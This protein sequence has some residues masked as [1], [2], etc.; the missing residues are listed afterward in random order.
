M[1]TI[2]LLLLCSMGTARLEA[3]ELFP[4]TE[5]ASTMPKQ[6]LGA[7]IMSQQYLEPNDQ[8]RNMTG[9]RLMYG[10]TSKLTV[11]L[12]A[13]VSNHHSKDLPPD[14]PDHNTPQ[15]G[16]PLPL[17]F[18]GV[19]IYA[20]YR[21][22]SKDGQNSHFRIGAYAEYSY[23]DVAHDEAEPNLM[24]DT[25]GFGGGIIATYLKK[26]F[27]VSFTGGVILPADYHGKVPDLLVGLP[28]VPATVQYGRAA[29][30][31]LSFGY[32][33][34]PKVYKNYNQTNLNL[35]IELLGKSYERAKVF[36]DNLGQPGTPYEVTGAG[37]QALSAGH[38]IEVHPG[39]QA[40]IKSNLR[41]D[42]SVGF[43]MVRKS[44][45]HFYPLYSI[46]IQRYFYP[47]AKK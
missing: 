47:R 37:M 29:N 44:Y 40:I 30:Y 15:I 11:M 32:L 27:A 35:Y 41:I 2:L 20:K 17:R 22:L 34:L 38:Y 16:V 7:R 18:N 21:L 31:S 9:I 43:P 45:A 8:Y 12:N 4:L 26:H 14:F 36:F 1:R 10:V 33:L 25:R 23:L 19:N 3:Q 39:I 5:P 24:D 13:T 42:L 46:G 6:V 28:A